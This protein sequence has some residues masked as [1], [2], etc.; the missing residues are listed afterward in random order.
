M[1]YSWRSSTASGPY[2]TCIGGVFAAASGYLTTTIGAAEASQWGEFSHAAWRFA[3]AGDAQ[4]SRFVVLQ[5]TTDATPTE[6]T[7]RGNLS[8][9]ER[10]V[11]ED[12]TCY[13][14][15][16]DLAARENATGDTAWWAIEGCVKRGSGAATTALVGSTY[17]TNDG[18]AGAAAWTVSVTADTTNGALKIEV[19]GEAAKTIRWVATVHSTKVLG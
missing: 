18:D 5:V 12:N 2:S 8:S 1:P 13:K 17:T 14:F 16:I 7:A 10:M 19:T 4:Y 15:K 6:M 9:T 3:T 11:L